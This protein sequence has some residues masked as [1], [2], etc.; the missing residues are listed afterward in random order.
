MKDT[1]ASIKMNQFKYWFVSD[2][3]HDTVN[4][5][6]SHFAPCADVQR[7]VQELEASYVE[8]EIEIPDWVQEL[9]KVSAEMKA[10]AV[11][12]SAG[13]ACLHQARE[14]HH[15]TLDDNVASLKQAYQA[16]LHAAGLFEACTRSLGQTVEHIGATISQN[17]SRTKAPHVDVEEEEEEEEKRASP[18][19]Q[20]WKSGD[21][22]N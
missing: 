2:A 17:N 9:T 21:K 20:T 16:L 4:L 7:Q 3:F 1:L 18:R 5:Y 6:I 12:L 19:R 10:V 22:S 13:L 11:L 14:A 8:E 15:S